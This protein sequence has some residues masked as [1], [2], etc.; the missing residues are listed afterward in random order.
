MLKTKH[1][2][3]IALLALSAATM[4]TA[5]AHGAGTPRHGGV[6]Q[7]AND[8]NFELVAE[9]DGAAIYLVDHD[10][11][12][13]SQGISGKLTVLQGSQK[14]EADIK[15]V[16]DN[17]LSAKGVKIASGAKIVAVLNNVDG[18]AVTVRFSVK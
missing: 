15:A 3:Q 14:S 1:A 9:A 8:V 16:G 2:V 12:M 6:V 7:V 18:K 13:P 10:E 5:L 11:P 17:K 4:N